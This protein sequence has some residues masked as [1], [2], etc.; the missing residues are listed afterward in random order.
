MDKKSKILFAFTNADNSVI[1]FNVINETGNVERGFEKDT[2]VN[3]ISLIQGSTH[4][5]MTGNVIQIIYSLWNDYI[6]Y[7]IEYSINQNQFSG[8]ETLDFGQGD[9]GMIGSS[10]DYVPGT[11]YTFFSGDQDL[12]QKYVLTCIARFYKDSDQNYHRDFRIYSWQSDIFKRDKSLIQAGDELTEYNPVPAL[13]KLIGVIEGPPPYT[14]NGYAYGDWGPQGYFPPSSLE[15]GTTATSTTEESTSIKSDLSVDVRIAKI[16]GGFQYSAEDVTTE[17]ISKTIAQNI[18][19]EPTQYN[20][21]GYR[22]FLKPV[23]QRKK[24]FI[25]DWKN[26]YLNY[27]FYLFKF[28]GPFV[29]YEPFK[30]SE[31]T[32]K[33]DPN[34]I[35]SYLNRKKNFSGYNSLLNMDFE[36]SIGSSQENSFSFNNTY[37]NTSSSGT[38]INVGV[39]KEFGDIFNVKIDYSYEITYQVKAISSFSRDFTLKFYC[40]GDAKDT[41][42]IKYFRG[43]FYWFLPK[44]GMDNWWIPKDFVKDTAW[45]MTYN[46]TTISKKIGLESIGYGINPNNEDYFKVLPNPVSNQV[47]FILNFPDN[48]IADLEIRDIYGKIIYNIDNIMLSEK[49]NSVFWNLTDIQGREVPSG[50]YFINMKSGTYSLTRKLCIIK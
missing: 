35:Y 41:S 44:T 10:D 42:H 31:F 8:I 36:W 48:G 23:I 46:L 39:D 12:N 25:F 43:K 27:S 33:L 45:L 34:D 21:F 32:E 9:Y 5:G 16:G 17:S 7:K 20:G 24:Y 15:Y 26:N 22:I 50:V 47:E 14:A 29:I 38:K 18:A 49:D 2:P 1:H 6:V 37:E 3:N 4:G 19:V 13:C 30:L 28:Y 11:F 40:P